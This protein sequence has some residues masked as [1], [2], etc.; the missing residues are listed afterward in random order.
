ML[1]R[2]VLARPGI[3]LAD[4]LGEAMIVVEVVV[5]APLQRTAGV[6]GRNRHD[7]DPEISPVV[8][9]PVARPKKFCVVLLAQAEVFL[10]DQRVVI[11]DTVIDNPRLFGTEL[12]TPPICEVSDNI[13]LVLSG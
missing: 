12:R 11:Y 4:A 6:A 7:R 1:V 5:G 3:R 8:V 13:R 10:K 2:Q 9:R